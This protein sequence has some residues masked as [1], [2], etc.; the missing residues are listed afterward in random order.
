M[1]KVLQVVEKEGTLLFYLAEFAL[2]TM[3]TNNH[4]VAHVSSTD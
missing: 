2:A 1:L 3:R 4:Q